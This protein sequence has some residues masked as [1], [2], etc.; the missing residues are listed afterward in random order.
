LET[1]DIYGSNALSRYDILA[2]KMFLT[3]WLRSKHR[4]VEA[5]EEEFQICRIETKMTRPVIRQMA[6]LCPKISCCQNNPEGEGSSRI[7]TA[8]VGNHYAFMREMTI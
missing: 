2:P 4:C 3:T 1:F 5:S 7:K 6:A 8:G